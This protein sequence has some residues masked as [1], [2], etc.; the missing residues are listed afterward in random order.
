MDCARIKELL[1][2]YIDDALDQETRVQ[3]ERHLD[4][5]QACTRE[6]ADMKAVVDHLGTLEKVHAPVDFLDRLHQRLEPRFT[7]RNLIR[8][9][10][11]PIRVK[12]PLEFATAAALLILVFASLQGP[13]P[14]K[15]MTGLPDASKPLQVTEK[16]P[17]N[18]MTARLKEEAA[19]P[20]AALDQITTMPSKTETLSE[21][22]PSAKRKEARK[23]YAPPTALVSAAPPEGAEEAMEK[24]KALPIGTP[25]LSTASGGIGDADP[26]ETVTRVEELIRRAQGVVVSREK[27]AETGKVRSLI[28]E[29][30]KEKH[31]TFSTELKVLV[32]PDM[33][34]PAILQ[35]HHESLRIRV[36]LVVPPEETS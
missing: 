9:F 33:P 10:F 30:P 13:G 34:P 32:G 4:G 1:S 28:A 22:A 2:E 5:C 27:E 31:E 11:V 35:E 19:E 14:E 3:V 24:E 12:L 26:Q 21:W 25:R 7:F 36:T 17:A 16:A 6:L 8:L 15:H 18:L 23:A 20:M 29:I